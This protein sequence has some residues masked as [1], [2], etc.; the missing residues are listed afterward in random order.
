MSRNSAI[1]VLN[2]AMLGPEGADNCQKFVDILGL[3][4]VFPLFMKTPKHAKAGPVPDELEGLSFGNSTMLVA[5]TNNLVHVFRKYI[6]FKNCLV[7]NAISEI[8]DSNF[9]RITL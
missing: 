9:Y 2:H 6:V 5:L 4:T 1:K 7:K 8:I 3:R